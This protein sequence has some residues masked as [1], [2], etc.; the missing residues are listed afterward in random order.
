MSINL[1]CIII[2]IKKNKE[3]VSWWFHEKHSS[4]LHSQLCNPGSDWV[5]ARPQED[6]LMLELSYRLPMWKGMLSLGGTVSYSDVESQDNETDATLFSTYEYRFYKCY[7]SL[8]NV[9]RQVKNTSNNG[10]TY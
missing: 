4:F 10:K 1:L 7:K 2:T 6:L 3:H 8:C 9:S 5:T